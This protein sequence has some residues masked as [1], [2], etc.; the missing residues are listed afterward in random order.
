MYRILALVI[1]AAGLQISARA[2]SID[3]INKRGTVSVSSAGLSSKGSQLWQF[4]GINTGHSLG[5]VS[6]TTGEL[7]SGTL[8]GGGTFS[9]AGSSFVVFGA[10][11]A[12]QPKGVIFDGAFVGPIQWALVNQNGQRLV[13]QLTGLVSGQ[14]SDGRTVAGSTSQTFHTTQ[15]Q[16]AKGI[17]HINMGTTRLASAPEPGTLG[18]LGL[19]LAAIG[20]LAR[21][22]LTRP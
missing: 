3:L 20:R 8:S 6:F 12:G 5:S 11:P 7:L 14:L 17:V 10:G 19:G 21:H 15:A 13:F 9:S 2:D 1:I 4:S 22:R 16:L 18:L